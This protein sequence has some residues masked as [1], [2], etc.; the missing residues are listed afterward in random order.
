MFRLSP[1]SRILS[2]LFIMPIW[3]NGSKLCIIHFGKGESDIAKKY[4]TSLLGKLLSYV[5]KNIKLLYPFYLAGTL[6]L[7][8][9]FFYS[10][11]VTRDIDKLRIAYCSD[12][13]FGPMFSKDRAVDLIERINALSTDIVILGGDYGETTNTGIDFFKITPNFK[14]RYGCYATIGNHDLWGNEDEFKNLLDVMKDKGITPL[15]NE[16]YI[17]EIGSTKLVL[18]S[19]DDIKMGEPKLDKLYEAREIPNSFIL[20]FPHSPDILPEITN[21]KAPVFDVALCGHTH[22][23][24]V[25]FFG[26]SVFSSSKYKDRYLSGWIEENGHRIMVSNGVGTSIMP[27]RIGSKPEYHLIELRTLEHS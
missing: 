24:Q 19:N 1:F 13:H 9:D 2:K 27:V 18:F 5:P 26:K 20:F 15:I 8:E 16:S 12:I 11:A 23:G 17:I 3:K 22:G 25:S 14:S 21:K 6:S 4:R 10:K 7:K